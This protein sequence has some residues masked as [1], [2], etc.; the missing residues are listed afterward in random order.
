MRA[1]AGIL[2]ALTVAALFAAGIA[3]AEDA[4]PAPAAGGVASPSGTPQAATPAPAAQDTPAA[5]TDTC[6]VPSYLVSTDAKLQ[7]VAD[8]I[9]RNRRLDI[10]V[11]GSASSML[12]GPDGASASYPARLELAL[13]EQLSGVTV[14]VGT[15]LQVKKTA[16]EVAPTLENLAK[17]RKPTLVI[18]QTGTM[19]AL[20]AVDPDDFRAAIETGLTGLAAAGADAILMNLQY[21]PRTETMI[22]VAP[23]LDN[24]R[25]GAEEHNV[26]LFD[27]FAMMRYWNESGRFDLFNTARGFGLAKQVH[28]CLGHTLAA[29]V[30]DAAQVPADEPPQQH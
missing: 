15:F 10:L 16:A 27:R 3:R 12:P 8:A 30:V 29:F 22:T 28:D 21:S 23:Y 18:W 1:C 14:N 13:K 19:D 6:E 17:E 25:V 5:A 4:R 7:R 11:V 24:I 9:R 2:A 20:H 26:P